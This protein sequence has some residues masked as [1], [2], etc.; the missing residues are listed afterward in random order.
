MKYWVL[1][2]L[3]VVKIF[4]FWEICHKNIGIDYTDLGI[5]AEDLPINIEYDEENEHLD[6]FVKYDNDISTKSIFCAVLSQLNQDV[7][8]ITLNLVDEVSTSMFADFED[9]D[10]NEINNI[11]ELTITLFINYKWYNN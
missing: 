7:K 1:L 10:N 8:Y 2:I 5:N 4:Y 11:K 6:V 3:L 9:K